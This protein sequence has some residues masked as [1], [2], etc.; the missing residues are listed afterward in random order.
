MGEDRLIQQIFPIAG[1]F[2]L[3]RDLAGDRSRASAG[4]ADHHAVADLGGGGRA[5]RQRLEIEIAERLH[6]A[7][8][9]FEIEAERVALHHAAVAEMQPDGFGLGDEIADRQHQPVIDQRR[10]CRRVRCRASPRCEA[11]VGMIECSPTTDDRALSRSN[12]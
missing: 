4:A 1:E 9:G 12:A 11:S 5:K 8:A 10:R 6:Q 2:L 3:G 7:E